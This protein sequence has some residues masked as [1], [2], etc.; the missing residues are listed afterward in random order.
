LE[1]LVLERTTIVGGLL[2]M[3]SHG[4]VSPLLAGRG[5]KEER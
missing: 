4:S 2:L 1:K 5:G 3:R